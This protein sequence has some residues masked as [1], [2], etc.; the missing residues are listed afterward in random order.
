MGGIDWKRKALG[1]LI[2]LVRVE[3]ASRSCAERYGETRKFLTVAGLDRPHY[4]SKACEVCGEAERVMGE[5]YEKEK[6]TS[7]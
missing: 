2:E 7:T 4:C 1:P 3:C 6:T 5:K